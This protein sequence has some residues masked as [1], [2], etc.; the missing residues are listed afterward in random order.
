MMM[1]T[2]F[3]LLLM[4]LL[5]TLP[6]MAQEE[7]ADTVTSGVRLERLCNT[8]EFSTQEG[9]LLTLDGL[10]LF[11]FD[12]GTLVSLDSISCPDVRMCRL[13]ANIQYDDLVMCDGYFIVKSGPFIIMLD[14]DNTR[15]LSKFDTPLFFLYPGGDDYINVVI[16]EEDG[17]WAWY[18]FKIY[19]QKLEC[20]MRMTTPITKVIDNLTHAFVV[21][22]EMVYLVSEQGLEPLVTCNRDIID[23]ASTTLGLF[24][25]SDDALFL[26]NGEEGD[27]EA[28]IEDA[29]YGIYSD[30]DV[31]YVVMQ[32]GDILRL[33]L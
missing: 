27:S 21:S 12:Q 20:V 6:V 2:I 10:G 23:A 31:I 13:K 19:S 24:V 7:V 3:T 1:K 22:E 28:I 29:L 18:T 11:Y 32:N 9:R 26:T 4:F 30:G 8:S 14:G 33:S 15:I 16:P 25:V 17:D 5:L